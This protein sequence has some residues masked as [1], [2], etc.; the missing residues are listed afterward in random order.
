MKKV[1]VDIKVK[2]LINSKFKSQKKEIIFY[3]KKL[4]QNPT[5]GDYVFGINN[6]DCREIKIKGIR[7]FTIQYRNQIF[8]N[9]EDSFFDTIKIMDIAKKNKRKE[10]QNII[11]DIKKRVK[12]FGMDI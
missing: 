4:E 7:V 10:Q 8:I 1:I 2:E 3:F 5:L 12:K 9:L 11:N 6:V